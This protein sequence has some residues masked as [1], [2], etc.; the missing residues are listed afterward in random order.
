MAGNFKI[1]DTKTGGIKMVGYKKSRWYQY[2]SRYKVK[3]P[4]YA[5][6]T[7]RD[8]TQ[9]LDEIYSKKNHILASALY[10]NPL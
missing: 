7:V 6:L 5:Q 4:K 10:Y 3:G 1:I 8:L 2:R 9:I